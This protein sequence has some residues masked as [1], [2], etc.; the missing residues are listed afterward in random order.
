MGPQ[1]RIRLFPDVRLS[2]S[3]WGVGASF[4]L[5]GASVSVGL[6]ASY[7]N[8]DLAGSRASFR[9]QSDPWHATHQNQSDATE[10]EANPFE[11]GQAEPAFGPMPGSVPNDRYDADDHH[12]EDDHREADVRLE[13]S[14]QEP[15][16]AGT[17]VY[18]ADK[19]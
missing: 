17:R 9:S 10:G 7:R 12:G 4:D 15:T 5:R 3:G 6:S 8:A 13:G 19:P 11:A 18:R 2:L 16:V 1:K 14:E